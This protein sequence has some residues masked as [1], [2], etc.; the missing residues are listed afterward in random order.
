MSPT[1]TAVGEVRVTAKDGSTHVVPVRYGARLMPALKAA[2]IGVV[3]MCGGH[4][5][6]GTCHVYVSGAGSDQLGEPDLD[7][8]DM[9]DELDSRRAES[10][11][12]C[13]IV[14]D[15]SVVGLTFTVA[16]HD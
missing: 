7:E 5:A 1:T 8:Q 6:C 12:A 2:N 10:R 14:V 4:A 9:L 3:G 15:E 11:L 16:P 13:Q